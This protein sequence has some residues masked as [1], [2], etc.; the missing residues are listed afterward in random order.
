MTH[1]LQAD[2][3]AL[4]VHGLDRQLASDRLAGADEVVRTGL[5]SGGL[6]ALTNA[7]L[8][9]DYLA[10]VFYPCGRLGFVGS[11]TTPSER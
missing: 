1:Q 9:C 2:S 6:L 4:K 10:A 11:T 3:C 8:G 5:S 7:C